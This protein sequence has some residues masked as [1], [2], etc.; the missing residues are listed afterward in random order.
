[1][2]CNAVATIRTKL[3][4]PQSLQAAAKELTKEQAQALYKALLKEFTGLEA[5]QKTFAYN[6]SI[7]LQAGTLKITI[8]HDGLK[9][10][11][12][13]IDNLDWQAPSLDIITRCQEQTIKA[14]GLIKQAKAIAAI[15]TR[16]L[17]STTLNAPNGATIIN[18]DL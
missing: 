16:Y 17:G 3:A 8:K 9:C 6:Q 4:L 12:I 2:P 7:V 5:E 11:N 1:M 10:T 15:K 13:D 14:A 18:L